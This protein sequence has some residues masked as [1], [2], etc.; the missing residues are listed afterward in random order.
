MLSSKLSLMVITIIFVFVALMSMQLITTSAVEGVVHTNENHHKLTKNRFLVSNSMEGGSR[1]KLLQDCPFG[2][3]MVGR[4]CCPNLLQGPFLNICTIIEPGVNN[5]VPCNNINCSTGEQCCGFPLYYV[6]V[7][8]EGDINNCGACL[9]KCPVGEQ[10]CSG[11]CV[12]TLTN[13]ANC[14][15]C[16]HVCNNVPC[17]LGIC[18]AYGD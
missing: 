12:N 8:L 3:C 2:A 7:A 1:R 10:C 18:G 17:T 16:G 5:C 9:N 4:S 11:K 15:S 6:C 14:G 13:S